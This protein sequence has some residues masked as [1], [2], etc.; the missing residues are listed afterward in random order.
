MGIA[1]DNLDSVQYLRIL[2]LL[3]EGEIEGFPSARSIDKSTSP[4]AYELAAMKDIYLDDVPIVSES[5]VVSSS[6]TEL[7]DS[8]YNLPG[9]GGSFTDNPN[10]NDAVGLR[11]G[12]Q[13]QSFLQG[14]KA[15]ETPVPVGVELTY[16]TPVARFVTDMEVDAIRVTV[17]IPQLSFLTTGGDISGTQ[18]NIRVEVLYDDPSLGADDG[19]WKT[20]PS[21]GAIPSSNDKM[22]FIGRTA[23]LYQR[24]FVVNFSEKKTATTTRIGVRL[25][26]ETQMPGAVEG[27]QRTDSI[28]WTNYN[29]VRWSAL[30]Y[31]NSALCAMVLDSEQFSSVPKRSYRIRGIKVQIPSNSR[32]A[33]GPNGRGAL[34]FKDEPWDGTFTQ[35]TDGGYTYGGTQ[36]TSDPAWILWDLLRNSRYGLGDHIDTS[37]LDKWA[38]FEASQYCSARNTY[39]TDGRN[40]TTDDY[41]S[42]TGKHGLDDGTGTFEPRFSCSVNIQT[43]EEAYK[44]INDMCSVFRAMPFWSTG[45][46]AVSQDRPTSFSYC[47][48]PANVVGGNFIYSGS[49]LKTRHTCVQ[50][51]YMDL[52]ARDIQYELVEDDDAIAKYGVI[53]TSI[54]AFACTS[55]GQAR[56]LGEWLLYTEQNETNTI[57]FEAAA[58]A[59]VVVRPGDVIQ[60]YDPVISGERRGG[61]VNTATTT[62]ITIDDTTATVIPASNLNPVIRVLLSDGTFGS[63]S[64]SSSAGSVITLATAL[65]S[66]PQ[67]GA[68]FVISSDDVRPTLWRVLSVS[69]QDGLTYAITGVSYLQDKYA[70]VER[71]QSIPVRDVTN[72][73]TPPPATTNI[74]AE[75]TLYESNGQVASRIRVSWQAVSQAWQYKFRYRRNTGVE[76]VGGADNFIV[77]YSKV[78]EFIILDADEGTYEIEITTQNTAGRGSNPATFTFEAIGKTAPPANIASLNISPVDAHTAELH[79]PQTTDIDVRIGGTLEI[80][81]TPHT[82]A[83]AVWSKS[84]KI[85]PAVNGS[86]TRKIVPLKA[87]TYFI[88]AKDSAG[89]YSAATGIPSVQV[90]LPEPQDLEVVQTYTENPNFTGTFTRAFNSVTEG[91]ISLSGKGLID[92]ITDFD[93]VTNLDFFGGVESTGSYLFANT[94]DLSAKYDVELLANLELRNI[95]PDDFWDARTELIDSWT[96]IDADDFNETDAELYVRSTADDPSGTPT[97]STWEPFVNSTKRGRGFQFKIEM[98]TDNTSQDPIIETLGVTVSLQR[99]TEQQRN[100]SSGTS[101]KAVTFPS[102]FYSTPSITITATNMATGDFFELSS[103]SR[104]GFTIT[105]KASGGSI[106]DR[107][108]DYQAV[109]HGKEIT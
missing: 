15:G 47:F 56:R 36:W 74:E 72:L 35:S 40:G 61:R 93:A 96:D 53:K 22:R 69:E 44:L 94:L 95:N 91:G 6:T 33:L 39:T 79:W 11:F 52:N 42:Q 60:V 49:S 86:S 73:N 16:E 5:A 59:G 75:E 83:N 102:A 103:V 65:A 57:A 51:A 30:R 66:A 26:R 107:N 104:T 41:D 24:S 101:A 84:Q 2:D 27:E 13:S 4:R 98:A 46:L 64:I 32:P 20:D 23:D 48:S 97:W 18:V 81:H 63:S 80:R 78:P 12:T 54:S 62:Q 28:F 88:R 31:P 67:A 50:V 108:F 109:G 99:R 45:A 70:H 76:G 105:F 7:A 34:I 89:N 8:D 106:V 21:F 37:K 68:P 1:K 10:G 17:S 14:Y 100:I 29:E 87:G 71:K 38:F 19:V 3:S 77:A 9:V 85:V 25:V 55:R 58:D 82:D 92:D 90:D 43:Q